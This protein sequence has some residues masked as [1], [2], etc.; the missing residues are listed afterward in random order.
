MPEA[1]QLSFSYKEVVTAL[2][3]AANIHEGTWAVF[4]RFGLGAANVG[5]TDND[6]QPAAIVPLLEIGIQKFEKETNISVDA[7]K[8]NPKPPEKSFPEKAASKAV[9]Q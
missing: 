6:V 3:K 2:L 1:S 4:V 7:A 8:V 5:Q 9:K